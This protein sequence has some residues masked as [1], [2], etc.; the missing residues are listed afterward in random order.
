MLRYFRN[1]LSN[2]QLALF[3][4]GAPLARL[5]CMNAES[6]EPVAVYRSTAE[7][8]CRERLLVLHA[9]GIPGGVLRAAGDFVVVVAPEHAERAYSE[10]QAY[11]SENVAVPLEPLEEILEPAGVGGTVAFTTALMLVAMLAQREFGG[12]DWYAAGRTNAGRIQHGEWWR[13]V[14]ALTLHADWAHLTGNLLV[15]GVVG[16]LASRALGGGRAWLLILLAGAAGNLLNALV[17]SPEHT[18]VGASTAVFAGIGL[19]AA[20]TWRSRRGTTNK[21]QRWAPLIGGVLLLS[22]LGTG[23]GRTDVPAHLFGFLCGVLTGTAMGIL[24]LPTPSRIWVQWLMGAAAM[25]LLMASWL[26]A[27]RCG[28]RT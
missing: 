21:M 4:P 10:L 14:T 18:S 5:P 6:V 1:S 22:F 23:G 12:F 8:D 19:L 3:P 17:R 13:T 15:G 2:R 25:A 20:R 9:V 27:L 28:G 16:W 11:A 7:R 26:L 24:H